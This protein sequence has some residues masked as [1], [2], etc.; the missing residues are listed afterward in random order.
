MADHIKE[1]S[2]KLGNDIS[3]ANG[4]DKW[5]I[6]IP[7]TFIIKPNGVIHTT[8]ANGDYRNRIEPNTILKSLKELI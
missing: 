1:L 7:A 8:Y 5:E 6:P 4:S 3:V 2:L